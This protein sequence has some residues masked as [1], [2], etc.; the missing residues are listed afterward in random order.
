M[1]KRRYLGKLSGPLIDRVDLRVEMHAARAGAFAAAGG[2]VHGRV[3]DAGGRCARGGAAERWLPHGF[4]TNAEVS[5]AL[6]RRNFG[7]TPR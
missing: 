2:R 5:G 7:W 4:R 1:V 3:R 6:L